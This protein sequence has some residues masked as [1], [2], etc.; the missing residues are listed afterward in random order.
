[1]T[2]ES[3]LVSADLRY[4]PDYVAEWILAIPHYELTDIQ[5]DLGKSPKAIY[6]QGTILTLDNCEVTAANL[7]LAEEQLRFDF[8]NRAALPQR[9]HRISRL[10]HWD[11][12]ITGLTIR[13]G[14]YLPGIATAFEDLLDARKRILLIGAPGSGKTTQLRDI[15]H[16]LAQTQNTIVVDLNGEI[17][18]LGMPAHECIGQARQFAVRE[19]QTQGQALIEALEN[20][21]PSALV[22]DEISDREQ[23]YAARSIAER[24]VQLIA[25]CHGRDLISV[26]RNPHLRILLGGI[27]S[28]AV[29]DS[30][31]EASGKLPS[32]RKEP[33]SFDVICV[34]ADRDTILVYPG[35]DEA[36]D[37]ILAGKTVVP[38][39]RRLVGNTVQI[40]QK[41][42]IVDGKPFL[43]GTIEER[44][45]SRK[46][47]IKA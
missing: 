18:G 23:A 19:G 37:A 26:V 11:G 4:L 30:R 14:R 32:F 1:M 7:E 12:A 39:T 16:H 10:Q 17:A 34:L 29:G 46:P 44:V 42:G 36:V 41:Y 38:E 40:L 2:M 31:A 35:V 27:E 6:G 20:H 8:K 15:A 47:K 28:V 43:E 13:V 3:V 9:L 22:V 21:T 45:Q 24:G 33:A 25:T 5:I